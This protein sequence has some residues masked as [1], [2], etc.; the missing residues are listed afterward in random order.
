MSGKTQ[1]DRIGNEPIRGSLRL[2]PVGD[3]GKSTEMVQ[4]CGTKTNDCNREE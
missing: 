3:E 1:K 4:S 2:T